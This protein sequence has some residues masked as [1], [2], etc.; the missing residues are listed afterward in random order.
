[1]KK[2]QM[3]LMK[4]EYSRKIALRYLQKMIAL[5]FSKWNCNFL[6]V[7]IDLVLDRHS[8][9]EVW[10]RLCS[11]GSFTNFVCAEKGIWPF[12]LGTL[13]LGRLCNRTFM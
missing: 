2:S 13:F 3:I 9:R 1:M 4:K 7:F 6:A 11:K 5:F 12:P 8:L 10:G